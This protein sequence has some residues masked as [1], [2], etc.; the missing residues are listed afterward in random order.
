MTTKLN[1]MNNNR[2]SV[3]FVHGPSLCV[4]SNIHN[5]EVYRLAAP[6]AKAK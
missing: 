2:I 6:L 5:P 1:R 4:N 3:L